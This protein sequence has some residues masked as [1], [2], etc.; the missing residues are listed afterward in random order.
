MSIIAY[1]ET[2]EEF[3]LYSK[4]SVES[5]TSLCKKDS[6]PDDLN[7]RVV[8]FS[9]E[10]HIILGMA[11]K[12]L[13]FEK[14]SELDFVHR[15][16]LEIDLTFLGIILFLN[17]LK[18]DTAASILELSKSGINLKIITGDSAFTGL[19]VANSLNLIKNISKTV[20]LDMEEYSEEDSK[21]VIIENPLY[22]NGKPSIHEFPLFSK[23]VQKDSEINYERMFFLKGVSNSA[24]DF[25][26]VSFT[27]SCSS[28]R[29]QIFSSHVNFLSKF[30]NF[31]EE[32][33]IEDV[34]MTGKI[35]NY[36]FIDKF[37]FFS[38]EE[39]KILC[40]LLKKIKV[41]GRMGN[42]DK[43]NLVLFLQNSSFIVGMIGDGL[44]DVGALKQADAGLALSSYELGLSSSFSTTRSSLT[45][46]LDLLLESRKTVSSI[47]HTFKFIS[48]YSLM[49]FSLVTLLNILDAGITDNQYLVQDLPVVTLSVILLSFTRSNT[50]LTKDIPYFDIFSLQSLFS[51]VGGGLIQLGSQITMLMIVRN[52]SWFNEDRMMDEE[53]YSYYEYCASCADGNAVFLCITMVMI[54]GLLTTGNFYPNRNK[55]Y[56][57][58][59]FV[60]YFLVIHIYFS[61]V[62]LYQPS[63]M[64]WLDLKDNLIDQSFLYVI[65]GAS[66][67]ITFVLWFWEAF[68]CNILINKLIRKIQMKK[69][70]NFRVNQSET[71][72]IEQTKKFKIF[73][74]KNDNL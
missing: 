54:N 26:S 25:T 20:Y 37:Q 12:K 33:I 69:M 35:F 29:K 13:H 41:L 4:G 70:A 53:E 34:V 27:K 44:N 5:I 64:E 18:T 60:L 46:F 48:L 72:E 38:N 32:R 73:L 30:F 39:Q 74:P 71:M 42:N 1:N 49:Q 63:R 23:M 61:L 31:L 11:Y 3:R 50:K 2:K 52:Q 14:V 55:F 6:I 16:E 9:K 17:P 65:F 19:A 28:Q 24:E 51:M 62:I 8:D 22:F 15:N 36:L 45:S 67:I 57:N 43:T 21:L 68:V 40:N 10:G 59:L 56:K 47:I 58:Y 66:W 7:K